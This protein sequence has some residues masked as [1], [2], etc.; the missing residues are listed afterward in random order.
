[1]CTKKPS[2]KLLLTKNTA[3]VLQWTFVVSLRPFQATTNNTN[4]HNFPQYLHRLEKVDVVHPDLIGHN[5]HS[6]FL[7]SKIIGL[8]HFLSVRGQ[9]AFGLLDVVE[10]QFPQVDVEHLDQ[11]TLEKLLAKHPHKVDRL[12]RG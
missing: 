7:Q 4:K 3:E 9:L 5:V 11:A 12:T 8:S 2:S 10:I 6:N 1:M